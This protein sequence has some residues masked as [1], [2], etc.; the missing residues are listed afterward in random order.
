MAKPTLIPSPLSNLISDA[1]SRRGSL[2][3]SLWIPPQA[4]RS[5]SWE[6]VA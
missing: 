4:P 3:F 5:L 6:L 2:L 1:F